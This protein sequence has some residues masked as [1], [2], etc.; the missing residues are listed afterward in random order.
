MQ[1]GIRGNLRD[2]LSRDSALIVT[3][4]NHRMWRLR[5]QLSKALLC[6]AL[7]CTS[8]PDPTYGGH[9]GVVPSGDVLVG[10]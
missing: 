10:H 9:S 8:P 6:N 5:T 3:C 2:S 1:G 7:Y 4:A